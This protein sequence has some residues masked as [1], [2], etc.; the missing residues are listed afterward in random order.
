MTEALHQGGLEARRLEASERTVGGDVGSWDWDE[1]SRRESP[2]PPEEKGRLEGG[3]GKQTTWENR[4]SRHR[5]LTSER[6]RASE[7]VSRIERG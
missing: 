5:F 4:V 3:E 7:I 6:W 1:G 2:S